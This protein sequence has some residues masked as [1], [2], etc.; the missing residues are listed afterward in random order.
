MLDQMQ[1]LVR[2]LENGRPKCD[3]RRPRKFYEK[4]LL[5][6]YYKAKVPTNLLN[7]KFS[8]EH[9]FPFSSN[10][11]GEID[12]DRVGNIV[13]IIDEINNKRNNKHISKY[14]ELD[15]DHNFINFI[16]VLPKDNV[17]NIVISHSEIKPTIISNDKYIEYCKSTEQLYLYNFL[18]CLFP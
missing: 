14:I 7:N 8:L 18:K 16:D 3:K 5:F 2:L 10:W 9:I 4:C 12:I 11:E 6:Y 17:Y 1:V 13:P 15:I